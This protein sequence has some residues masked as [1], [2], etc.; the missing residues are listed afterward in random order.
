MHTTAAAAAADSRE[1]CS[2]IIRESKLGSRDEKLK[3]ILYSS[4]HQVNLSAHAHPCPRY[5]GTY[6]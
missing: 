3:E 5:I 4:A 6:T 1:D 2:E